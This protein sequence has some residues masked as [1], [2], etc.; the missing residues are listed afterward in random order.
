MHLK[1]LDVAVSGQGL[2]TF[3]T[4]FLLPGPRSPRSRQLARHAGDRPAL[5]EKTLRRP[6]EVLVRGFHDLDGNRFSKEGVLG[7]E[8]RAHSPLTDLLDK[9]IVGDLLFGHQIKPLRGKPPVPLGQV[10]A[11]LALPHR[12]LFIA[13]PRSEGW[14]FWKGQADQNSVYIIFAA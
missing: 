8:D 1:F 14:I 4:T 2:L 6:R 7:L 9:P 13:T 12:F 5:V 3:L 10:Y 11:D